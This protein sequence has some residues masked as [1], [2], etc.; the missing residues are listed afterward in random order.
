[1]PGRLHARDKF[2]IVLC[3][4]KAAEVGGVCLVLMVQGHLAGLTLAHLLIASKTGAIAVTPLLGV[5]MTRHARHLANRWVVS[6]LLGGFGFIADALIHGSHYPGA[7]TEA[8]LT[9]FGA[10]VL[11]LALSYTALGRRID[12][13]AESFAHPA[14]TGEQPGAARRLPSTAE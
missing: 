7:Y 5:T 8:A 12:A 13:L 3:G 4:H 14:R 9:G 10:F 11:S 1:M 2:R 6:A